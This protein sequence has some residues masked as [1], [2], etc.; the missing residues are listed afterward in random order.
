MK[1][2]Q[3]SYVVHLEEQVISAAV[4]QADEPWSR[5]PNHCTR[6]TALVSL[7]IF[8][9]QPKR[10]LTI[11]L[12]CGFKGGIDK[13]PLTASKPED[14]FWMSMFDSSLPKCGTSFVQVLGLSFLVCSDLDSGS[15][16]R[17]WS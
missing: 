6:S 16:I 11:L 15:E 10:I 1:L 13:S 3:R 8:H 14:D 17:H 2:S 12:Y 5:I 9:K 4:N 7:G